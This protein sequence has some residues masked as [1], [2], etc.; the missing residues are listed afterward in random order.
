MQVAQ[1][2][3]SRFADSANL[4]FVKITGVAPA[5]LEPLEKVSDSVDAGKDQ[6]VVPVEMI[7]GLVQ[8]LVGFQFANFDRWTN[9]NLGAVLSSSATNSFAWFEARVITTVRPARGFGSVICSVAFEV[10]CDSKL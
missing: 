9:H 10:I 4:Q 1:T 8:P 2:L 7:D 6:P 3:G 5:C